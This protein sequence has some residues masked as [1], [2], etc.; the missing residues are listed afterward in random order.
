MAGIDGRYW[1]TKGTP[2]SV[3]LHWC[4]IDGE[5]VLSQIHF[6]NAL[7]ANAALAREYEAIKLSAA[8]GRHID[9]A[10]YAA[11]KSAFIEMVLAQ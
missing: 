10:G 8:C 6:R 11:R 5:V 3:N 1:F 7:R 9:S 2:R 4:P